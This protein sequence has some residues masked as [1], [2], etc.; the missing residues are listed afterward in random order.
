MISI[1]IETTAS[2]GFH[3]RV[4]KCGPDFD[5][6]LLGC[7]DPVFDC[8]A[9]FGYDCDSDCDCDVDFNGDHAEQ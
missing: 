9:A 4:R 5:F 2:N 3:G 1:R 7:S 6:E 8:D